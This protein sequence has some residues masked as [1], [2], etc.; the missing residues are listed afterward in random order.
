MFIAVALKVSD[1][2]FFFFLDDR[3]GSP[4]WEGTGEL[5]RGTVSVL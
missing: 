2:I 4:E 3:Q 5:I 1:T